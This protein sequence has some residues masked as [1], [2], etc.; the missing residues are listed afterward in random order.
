MEKITYRQYIDL[1]LD[2]E[3]TEDQIVAYSVPKKGEGS[4]FS[5]E[6]AP[7]PDVVIMSES[8]VEAENA[9][10][11]GNRAARFFRRNE[12]NRRKAA[13]DASPVLVSEGDSWFQFPFFLKE[14]VDQLN[15]DFMVWSVGAAGDTAENMVHRNPEYMRALKK[16]R[17]SVKGFLFSAAGNDIIGEDPATGRPVLTDILKPFNGNTSD[18]TG[19]INFAL[20]GQKVSFL[21]NAYGKVIA[22]VRAKPEFAQLPIFIHGYD[23][24]FPFPFGAGD[25]RDPKWAD[26]DQWL[27]SAMST[28]GINDPDHRRAI[29]KLLIDT[30]YDMLDDLAGNSAQSQVWVVD[31][32]GALPNVTDWADEIHATSAGYA[33]VAARFKGR[34]NDAF[35]SLTTG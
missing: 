22:N 23:Y 28:K 1:L 7:N 15:K 3:T 25:G 26:K 12:F 9:M 13:G 24:V 34:I 6:L 18:I 20:L 2:P 30:L 35:A 10:Q 29:I 8:D 32:R 16:Q 4:A 19:H 27:G 5:V 14:T 21:R 17:K 31:C 11:I 33:K